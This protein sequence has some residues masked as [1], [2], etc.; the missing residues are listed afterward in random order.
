[1]RNLHANARTPSNLDGLVE[2]DE[3][4]D[5]MAALIAHVRGVELAAGCRNRCQVD[6]LFKAGIATRGIKQTRGK[7]H[8]PSIKTLSH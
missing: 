7:S 8:S 5:V 4:P 6:D 3:Q 2:G 1:M